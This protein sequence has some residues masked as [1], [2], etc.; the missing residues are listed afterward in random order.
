MNSGP[1]RV[2]SSCVLA[3]LC[4]VFCLCVAAFLVNLVPFDT[5]VSVLAAS[6][7][8]KPEEFRP[9][10]AERLVYLIVLCAGPVLLYAFYAL[11][12]RYFERAPRDP[13][14]AKMPGLAAGLGIFWTA[15]ALLS[16]YRLS[17]TGAAS[18]AA[19]I[20]LACWVALPRA[21][22]ARDGL[23]RIAVAAGRIIAPLLVLAVFLHG[24]FTPAN[25]RET[26]CWTIHFPAVFHSVWEV[27]NGR[28]LLHDFAN[29]YG[30]YPHF[31]APLFKLT[32]LS[33]LKFTAVMSGLA[34]GSYL[35]LFAVVRREIADRTRLY[36]SFALAVF[37]HYFW[38]KL[39]FD[40]VYFQYVPLRLLFPALGL[41][42]AQRWCYAPA[43]R[44][45]AFAT[46]VCCAGMLWN[47]D[48][49]LVVFC[50]WLLTLGF[51]RF[52]SDQPARALKLFGADIG[53]CACSLGLVFA[54]YAGAIRLGYGA[55]PDFSRLFSYHSFY[56]GSGYYM[57]P[58]R[59]L[60]LWNVPALLYAGGLMHSVVVLRRDARYSPSAAVVFML[61]VLGAG[62]FSYYQ[63]RSHIYN[64]YSVSWPAW[65]LAGIY[66][67]RLLRLAPEFP[68]GAGALEWA[69]GAALACFFSV[70][71]L[72]LVNAGVI[73]AGAVEKLAFSGYDGTVVSQ[74]GFIG[75][76]AAPGEKIQIFSYRQSVLELLSGRRSAKRFPALVETV[77]RADYDALADALCCP[78]ISGVFIDLETVG[79][80][81]DN[82]KIVAR[83]RRCR[84]LKAC[85]R[86]LCLFK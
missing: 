29:Q 9:E 83:T 36:W 31:L 75:A 17:L 14:A 80:V 27:F 32:G 55:W 11:W 38:G 10:P 74:A 67:D 7:A 50:A 62:L 53:F 56:Y 68:G 40:E 15:A 23:G 22:A 13:L 6:S 60:D 39:S 70:A 46:A 30:L 85:D 3:V 33:V 58:M 64:L 51:V 69:R 8:V 41:W 77:R 44:N 66:L 82:E 54:G 61:S 28:V 35:L 34:A 2:F 48:S 47:I 65:L 1:G 18:W 12:R 20:A 5:D 16:S 25:T 79:Y 71:G 59:V 26:F 81:P 24:L 21:R 45:H 19:G 57:L 4:S 72:L 63:G 76:N 84:T 37:L 86:G 42:L 52:S 73:A 78:E 49:G 43:A